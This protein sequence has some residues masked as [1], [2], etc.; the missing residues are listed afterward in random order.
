MPTGG[1]DASRES[2]EAWISAGVACVGVGS[3]L[4]TKEILATGDFAA[5][6]A[7]V[8]QVVGWI[9]EIR[10]ELAGG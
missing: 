3:K 5:L 4:V 1:V 10:H 6:T 8:R 7:N 9:E 2:L